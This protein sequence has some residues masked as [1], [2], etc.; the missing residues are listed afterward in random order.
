MHTIEAPG[1]GYKSKLVSDIGP[2]HVSIAADGRNDDDRTF[3]KECTLYSVN[4]SGS[5]SAHLALELF[6]A[7]DL[8]VLGEGFQSA[9]NPEALRMIGRDYTD[10]L[11]RY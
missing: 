9:S 2:D 5:G 4:E 1:I 10:I 8:H 11:T 3:L 6:H 7:A